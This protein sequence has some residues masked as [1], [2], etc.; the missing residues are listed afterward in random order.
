MAN[1]HGSPAD[2]MSTNFAN[3]EEFSRID[4]FS[5]A[6]ITKDQ[7]VQISDLI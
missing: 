3:G 6:N 2:S 7:Y 1:I 5:N 4:G